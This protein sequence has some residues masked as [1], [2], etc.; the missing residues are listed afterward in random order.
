MLMLLFVIFDWQHPLFKGYIYLESC[1]L[2]FFTHSLLQ[3]S[4]DDIAKYGGVYGEK[5]SALSTLQSQL[6]S[7]QS[8]LWTGM[9]GHPATT[10][11]SSLEYNYDLDPQNVIGTCTCTCMYK[12][13]VHFPFT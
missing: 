9:H 6:Q 10:L 7:S 3:L 8:T 12:M 11:T 5:H 1:V 4:F 2:S 13:C